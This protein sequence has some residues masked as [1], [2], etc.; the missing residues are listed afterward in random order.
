MELNLKHLWGEKKLL[1][2]HLEDL[3]LYQ[4]CEVKTTQLPSALWALWLSHSKG[5]Q[6]TRS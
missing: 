6:L 2:H 4:L 5:P 3:K 1:K